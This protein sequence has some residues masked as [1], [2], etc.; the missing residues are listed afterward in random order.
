[1]TVQN[2]NYAEFRS[3]L[4]TFD[5]L[6]WRSESALGWAIRLFTRQPVNHTGMVIRFA[7]YDGCGKDVVCTTEALK[8]GFDVNRLSRRLKAQKGY[9]L[10]YRLK[11]A[12][13]GLRAALGATALTLEGTPYDFPSLARSAIRYVPT[14]LKR[15]FCSEG[16]FVVGRACCLPV[17]S[18]WIKKAPRPGADM[19]SLGWWES[20]AYR[21]VMGDVS[22]QGAKDAK[23][24]KGAS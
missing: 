19:D 10:V 13:H 4:H 3:Q 23:K 18:R 9:C 6:E 11:P 14:D 21:L 8:N 7:E 24:T 20:T 22:R 12:Y 5:R 1:M 15:L 17:P 2:V 16:I